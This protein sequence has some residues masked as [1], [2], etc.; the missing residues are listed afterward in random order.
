MAT[1]ARTRSIKWTPS[2]AGGSRFAFIR[3][4]KLVELTIGLYMVERVTDKMPTSTVGTYETLAD[5][6]AAIQAEPP[7][8]CQRCGRT[9][10]PGYQIPDPG[11]PCPK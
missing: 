11:M 3:S 2:C 4:C 1:K 5:A 8:T 7:A 9:V 10:V 6:L